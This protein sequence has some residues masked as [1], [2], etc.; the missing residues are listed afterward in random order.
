M[1]QYGSGIRMMDALVYD[2]ERVKEALKGRMVIGEDDKGFIYE[3]CSRAEAERYILDAFDNMVYQYV[4]ANAA[5]KAYERLLRDMGI[6][7]DYNNLFVYIEQERMEALVYGHYHFG[8]DDCKNSE[9]AE[10]ES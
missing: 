6:K 4:N 10:D 1:G 2:K 3:D 7:I 5:G 9:E 8:N